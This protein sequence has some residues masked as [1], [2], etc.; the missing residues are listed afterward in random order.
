MAQTK[1]ELNREELEKL[2]MKLNDEE[3]LTEAIQR[4]AL[5]L[6]NEIMNIPQRGETNEW[7]R[8]RRK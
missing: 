1:K 4:L 5:I 6:S 7:K 8:K 2:R 3:Y